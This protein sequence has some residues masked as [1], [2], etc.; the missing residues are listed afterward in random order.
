MT[1][2][3]DELLSRIRPARAPAGLK[4]RV[5]RAARRAADEP[6]RPSLVERVWDSRALWWAWAASVLLLLGVNA[7]LSR[8]SSP[9]TG[10][11][12]TSAVALES[13]EIDDSLIASMAVP[14]G[15]HRPARRAVL[16]LDEV[17][18]QIDHEV[19]D[20]RPSMDAPTGG[21]T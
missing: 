21:T 9:P 15:R 14:R 20:P 19:R 5:L 13:A 3:E 11:E 8:A 1:R 10:D 12:R 7:Y 17:L 16:D 18:A 4:E 6:D 2:P